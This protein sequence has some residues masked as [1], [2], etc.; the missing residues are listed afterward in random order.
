[1][2]DDLVSPR[3]LGHGVYEHTVTFDDHQSTLEHDVSL[4]RV[5][6][7]PEIGSAPHSSSAAYDDPRMS[8]LT[9]DAGA[10]DDDD[11]APVASPPVPARPISA[12]LSLSHSTLNGPAADGLAPLQS[13]GPA[14]GASR[15]RP[16]PPP[17]PAR[18]TPSVRDILSAVPVA[19]SSSSSSSSRGGHAGADAPMATT[20]PG[21][22][23][24]QQQLVERGTGTANTGVFK[25]CVTYH[26]GAMRRDENLELQ[27]MMGATPPVV[28]ALKVATGATRDFPASSF[29]KL[30]AAGDAGTSTVE[31]GI[32]YA[33]GKHSKKLYRFA[34]PHERTTFCELL[35]LLNERGPA[36][37]LAMV[38]ERGRRLPDAALLTAGGGDPG[39]SGL[40]ARRTF[41]KS[42][43]PL[44]PGE[45]ILIWQEQASFSCQPQGGSR[46]PLVRGALYLTNYR[47]IFRGY[48]ECGGGVGNVC[49]EVAGAAA[50]ARA[51]GAA[52]A[53]EEVQVAAHATASDDEDEEL[54]TLHCWSAAAASYA[55]S[56]A[57][58]LP[59]AF[60]RADIPLFSVE[61]VGVA[62]GDESS[63]LLG[64]KDC[65]RVMFSFDQ[66]ARWV[67]ELVKQLKELAFCGMQ[68][69][70]AFCYQEAT[71]ATLATSSGASA[72]GWLAFSYTEEMQRQGLRFDAASPWRLH[73]DTYHLSPTYPRAFAV[74][75]ENHF[76]LVELAAV[77]RYRSN[78]RV[79]AVTYRH[80]NGALLV[81]C[82][83]PGVGL[84]GKACVEDE[85]LLNLY[86]LQGRSAA[87]GCDMQLVIFD[88][89]S[90]IAAEANKMKAKGYEQVDHYTNTTLHF[91]GIG[92]IHTMR[93]SLSQL[94]ELC[95]A[96]GDADGQT[97]A[98]L[99]SSGW[100]RHM[101]G[102]LKASVRMA[103]TLH[104]GTSVVNHCSDGWDRTAQMC[105]MSQLLLDP[106]FRTIK[107]FATLIEKVRLPPLLL[108]PCSLSPCNPLAATFSCLPANLPLALQLTR[109][110]NGIGLVLFRL[111]VFAAL[112][113]WHGE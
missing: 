20:N 93:D 77:A 17:A 82:S 37:A 76:P 21:A 103:R 64:C 106:H 9:D 63:M 31:V 101:Q 25:F 61:D 85:K 28:R 45:D 18:P 109:S 102:I 75:A 107:G 100:L 41:S 66:P 36:V 89:R 10:T 80:G 13:D 104:A 79:P 43:P 42:R 97:H 6:A 69:A 1:M 57:P 19:T 4:E 78:G 3:N 52:A 86:R 87:E 83:Q 22:S 50:T 71:L 35:H 48:S 90:K 105:A 72:N 112:R 60:M 68:R 2:A 15:A 44:L 23:M 51:A 73:S 81:R 7:R 8:E 16:A 47:V 95:A 96:G 70:F 111:Q 29:V 27:V 92:N 24:S 54:R 30:E 91:C 74:P 113:P 88:A 65:R 98:K 38:D 84:G 55:H 14:R 11:V 46:S 49:A 40:P 59:R 108:L 94:R 58:S 32:R 12:N 26:K 110:V 56:A 62:K 53:A 5:S 34:S 33:T 67:Q 39:S 99:H